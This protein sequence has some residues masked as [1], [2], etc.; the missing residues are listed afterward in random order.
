MAVNKQITLTKEGLLKLEEEL[1]N[2]KIVRRKEVSEK[3]KVALSFGDLSENSEYDEAKNEQAMVEARINEIEALL[4]NVVVVND[5]EISTDVVSVG[6]TVTLK[7]LKNGKEEAYK[8]VGST[9]AA[10]LQKKI[11]DESPVGKA[12]IGHK[13]GDIADAEVP[14]GVIQYE[15]LNISK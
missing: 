13:V 10:P 12:V 15:I 1:E 2:L 5:D 7:C 3:I 4:K 9:E 14:S 8:I 11:S 6:C